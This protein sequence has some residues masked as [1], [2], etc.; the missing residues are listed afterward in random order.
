M[1][2]LQ[3]RVYIIHPVTP[4]GSW[5]EPTYSIIKKIVKKQIDIHRALL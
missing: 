5:N 3:P 4:R 1:I 2:P